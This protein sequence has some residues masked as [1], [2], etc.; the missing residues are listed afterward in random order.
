MNLHSCGRTSIG[1]SRAARREEVEVSGHL[2]RVSVSYLETRYDNLTPRSLCTVKVENHVYCLFYLN[3]TGYTFRITL[4]TH[5]NGHA[6]PRSVKE[7]MAVQQARDAGFPP[8]RQKLKEWCQVLR[9]DD[10][11]REHA[12]Q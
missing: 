11:I 6:L 5:V 1:R 2:S 4:S 7:L 12:M 9:A 8:T 10:L 3:V